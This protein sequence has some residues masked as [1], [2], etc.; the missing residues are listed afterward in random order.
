MWPDASA[1]LAVAAALWTVAGRTVLDAWC[2]KQ[3]LRAARAQ[4]L[5]DTGLFR[6]PW[7]TGLAGSRKAAV[8]DVAAPGDTGDDRNRDW[9]EHVPVVPW[10]LDVLA[11][12]EQDLIFARR[13]HRAYGK[14]LRG[15]VAVVITG[16]VGLV[17]IKEPSVN[18]F[19][20]QLFVPLA[21]ALLDLVELP[22]RH[23]AAAR[24]PEDAEAD[25]DELWNRH[26][27]GEA[28]TAAD[29]RSVQNSIWNSRIT[30][31]ARPRPDAPPC[32]HAG[33]SPWWPRPPARPDRSPRHNCTAPRPPWGLSGRSWEVGRSKDSANGRFTLSAAPGP[34]LSNERCIRG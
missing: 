24:S 17:L 22:R 19:L 2:Q 6:L 7:S 20:V 28:L 8:E 34:G 16:A 12:Q 31:A 13:N 18:E 10:P 4:E 21:P 9:Y 3:N 25:V 27:D 26:A 33:P 5:H 14:V 29:C 1:A 23:E 32:R 11:C 15:A 30:R